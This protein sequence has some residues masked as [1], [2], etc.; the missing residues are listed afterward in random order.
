MS[1]FY[2]ASILAASVTASPEIH[3]K[4]Q[5]INPTIKGTPQVIGNLADPALNRDS[6]G[7][8]LFGTRALWV[9]RDSQHYDSDGIPNLPLFTSSA[10]WTDLTP[11]GGS[12]LTM[13]G[14]NNDQSFY[15]LVPGN[16]DSNQ[17]GVCPDGTRYP[18]WANSPPLV[19]STSD[20]LVVGYTWVGN[21]H[22]SGLTNLIAN[23]AVTLYKVSYTPGADGL[24][25]S[26]IVNSAFWAENDIPYG[27]YGSLN[28]DDVLY[29]W[30]QGSNGKVA[31]AKVSADQVD[32]SSQYQYYV[33][34]DWTSTKPAI[35][36]DSAYIESSSAGGQGTYYY[37]NP[38]ASY[39]W[40]GQAS[41][42]VS[43]DFY[44]TTAPAPEGPWAEPVNFYSGVNGNYSLGAYTLQANPALSSAEDN[45]IYLTYTKTDAVGDNVA[46][47]TTPLIKVEW[48]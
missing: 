21:Y 3:A 44:I 24:P 16:C 7:S 45:V 18:L 8:T 13:Y 20:D 19:T 36:D 12:N 2:F 11:G 38:W 31:L 41:S 6:C 32:N 28:Q 42:S 47:Y 34:G 23:P 14:Q 33:N 39:V 25:T 40:I 35:S 37:S 4:R 22:I 17:A 30:G 9:C 48:E 29:L 43:A 27:N 46:L 26:E 5:A 1:L 15:P 10:S